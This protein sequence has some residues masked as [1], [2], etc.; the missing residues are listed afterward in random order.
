MLYERRRCE[1][2]GPST[3]HKINPIQHAVNDEERWGGRRSR[4]KIKH[5]FGVEV[6]LD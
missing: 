2:D 1:G 6:D 4:K 3:I 5:I